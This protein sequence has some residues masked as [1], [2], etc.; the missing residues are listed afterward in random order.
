MNRIRYKLETGVVVGKGIEDRSMLRWS[1]ILTLSVSLL[2]ISCKDGNDS[3]PLPNPV[4]QPPTGDQTL[5]NFAANNPDKII[6]GVGQG[7]AHFDM[8]FNEYIQDVNAKPVVF[9]TYLTLAEIKQGNTSRLGQ[10][11]KIQNGKPDATDSTLYPFITLIG[12]S[13]ASASSERRERVSRAYFDELGITDSLSDQYNIGPP[14][15]DVEVFRY[16]VIHP[17][18][19]ELLKLGLVDK[20][21]DVEGIDFAKLFADQS[22]EARAALID[23]RDALL[24]GTNIQLKDRGE[25]FADLE[26]LEGNF[27]SEIRLLAAASRDIDGPVLIRLMFETI[28]GISRPALFSASTFKQAWIRFHNIMKEE[29]AKNAEF[30]FHPLMGFASEIEQWYP[31]DEVVNWVATS[32]FTGNDG[33]LA[34]WQNEYSFAIAHNKPYMVAESAPINERFRPNNTLHPEVWSNFFEH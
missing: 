27:D 29:G 28:G 22:D 17:D 11:K 34:F 20:G 19:W 7:L 13:V 16:F 3:T 2:L 26:I 30:V 14:S 21:Y 24:L 23:L 10:L 32:F 9:S 6:H 18:L 25:L 8:E 12:V 31:G 4:P 33:N 1:L 5:Y 15:F